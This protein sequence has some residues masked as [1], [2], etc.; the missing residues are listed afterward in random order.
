MMNDVCRTNACAR[1][2]ACA[3][4]GGRRRKTGPG[5][6]TVVELLV[7]V[8][9][10]AVLFA[11]LLP[12]L[13]RAREEAR[14]I[15]CASNLRQWGHAALMYAADHRGRLPREKADPDPSV[16][17]DAAAHNTWALITT[18]SGGEE[19]WF[20]VLS[21]RYL[22]QRGVGDFAADPAGRAG[23]SRDGGGDAFHVFH[24]PDAAFGTPLYDGPHFSLTFNAKL[25]TNEERA[26]LV[27]IVRPSQTPL[28]L[29]GGLPG[30]EKLKYHAAQKKFDGRPHVTFN[31]VVFRHRGRS[32]FVMTD[33]HVAVL[34]G[35]EVI[36][37][38]SGGAYF[39]QR[40]LVWTPNPQEDPNASR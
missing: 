2:H 28:F 39:P 12:S 30:E 11:I 32:N 20:N 19:L 25:N 5:A 26:N 31:R 3:I 40:V 15:R 35:R 36:D 18:W 24:C 16:P 1:S 17:W 6:F 29:E 10:I 9:I 27:R 4:N 13:G 22:R 23:F 7:A 38:A 34:A 8:G 21:Q 14:R 33:G 37:P